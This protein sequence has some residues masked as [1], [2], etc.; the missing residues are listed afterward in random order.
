MGTDAQCNFQSVDQH[1]T[2]AKDITS[3]SLTR[4]LLASK[5][6][7]ILRDIMKLNFTNAKFVPNSL[8]NI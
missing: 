7:Q 6:P 4:S 3:H 1:E 2:R 8:I 5:V